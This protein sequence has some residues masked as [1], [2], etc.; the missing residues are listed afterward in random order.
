MKLSFLSIII[1]LISSQLSVAQLVKS[2][3]E[4]AAYTQVLTKRSRKIV[5]QLHLNDPSKVK[6]ITGILVDQY[7][8]IGKIYDLREAQ[9]K[10]IKEADLSDDAASLQASLTSLAAQVQLKK[11]H[12][13]FIGKLEARLTPEQVN[14][15]KDG[16]TYNVLSVT[17]KGYVDMI[18]SL[19]EEQKTKIMANLIEAREYA[20]D[21]GSSEEKHWWFGKYK[22]RINNYLSKEGYNLDQEREAWKKRRKTAKNNK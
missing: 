17:Y 3:K 2:D 9:E 19:T 18:P 22:G 5:D 4:Q 12:R 15:I 7:K 1:I 11:L 13:A 16:M 20:I 6:A 10:L 21:G 14:K 8:G